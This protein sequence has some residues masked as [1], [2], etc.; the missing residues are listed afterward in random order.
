MPENNNFSQFSNTELT[1]LFLKQSLADSEADFRNSLVNKNFPHWDCIIITASNDSQA[2]GYRRQ[3]DYRRSRKMLPCCAD[4]L[5]VPDKDNKRVGSAG[6]TLSVI[7][8]LKQKY[9]ELRGKKFLVIHAGGNSSRTPQYS[10]LGK[11]FSPVPTAF[12]DTPA[13][14]FDMFMIT[15]SSIPGRIKDGM[16]LLSG[17]VVLLFNPLMCD[18]GASPAA[19]V[20]FKENIDTAKNHGVF[21]KSGDGNVLRFLHKQSKES[22]IKSGAADRR[23]NCNIDTGAL[24]LS[25]EI[26]EK[27]YTLIDT[28][29]KYDS[30]VNEKVRLSLY[31]DIAYCLA[32][33]STLDDFYN[34]SAEGEKCGE[35]MRA[36]RMLW[37]AV[38]SYN[39]K[40]L[41]ISP[42]R[43]IH[44][45]SIPEIMELMNSG[46][47]E[48]KFLNWSN[49]INS[50]IPDPDIAG[51]NS[52][53]SEKATV[54]KGTYL[55]VSYVHSNAKVGK[56]CFLS[57]ID[58][59]DEVIPDGVMMHGIK[60]KNGRF[61]CRIMS[62]C[63][64]PKDRLFFGQDL[65]KILSEDFSV[66]P[67]ALWDDGAEHTLWN[68]A[69]YPECDTIS[70]A[71]RAALDAY[72]LF[73][74]K[75]GSISGWLKQQ[76][77][78]LCS[79]LDGA[80][81]DAIIAWNKRMA[82][83]VHVN[84]LKKRIRASV[85]A[86]ECGG[87]FKEKDLTPIQR[88]W[89]EDEFKKIDL[90]DVDDFAYAIRIYYYLGKLLGN[91]RYVSK[92]F[93]LISKCVLSQS[94]KPTHYNSRLKIAKDEVTVRLPLRVNW[95]GGWTDT[96]PYCIENG[97]TVLNAAIL[98]NGKM[99]VEIKISKIP[100]YKIILDSRDLD[101]HAEFDTV[102]E[103]QKTGDP[104]DPFAIQKAC[105]AACGI[106]TKKGGDLKSILASLGGGFEMRTEVF[107]VPKGSGLGTSSI[108]CAATV[109]AVFEFFGIEYD[110]NRIF[111]TVL[112]VE[113]LM[114]T[115]GGWQDQIGGAVPGIKIITSSKGFGQ[116]VRVRNLSVP[117]K[118]KKELEERFCLIYTGQRRLARN[119][120]RNVVGKY[121]G[122]SPESI[123]A[124]AQIKTLAEKMS[125]SLES[126]DIKTF[127]ALLNEHWE[128]SKI[129]DK[130]STNTLIEQI[131]TGI[132]DLTDA[133][134]ICGAGGGGFLQV[135]LK[136]GVTKADLQNRLKDIFMDFP[137]DVWDCDISY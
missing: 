46:V 82:E 21:L 85:P 66:P 101:E 134:M 136:K 81:P 6:S 131:I 67:A 33:K 39:M 130:G 64:N 53:M 128:C 25:P 127:A 71:V 43:F 37:D 104:F 76:R 97:G 22:L 78:S 24:W 59:H 79:C 117:D 55:E 110:D 103:L 135:I 26:L 4:F 10:A 16:M 7:R 63:D 3:I 57:F 120:L 47:A 60:L 9:G 88:R 126:G 27:L 20:S 45:G 125:D 12:G 51:Y 1:S 77:Q 89:L 123:D 84:E 35:L 29:E 107:G 18:F 58:I 2:E 72:E 95:G 87:I 100:E 93:A 116:D 65:E 86:D 14:L 129:I 5:I 137:I 115:G 121:I 62:I 92:C 54:G 31:G 122:G 91:K 73:I 96:C 15:M 32:E 70:G 68:A 108:L 41:T 99:P 40:L 30:I 19:A 13:T 74:N 98:L 17:D 111:T 61:V 102:S 75:K 124:H 94:L 132:G 83:L 38:G 11:L 119:I 118:M 113:Q 133:K 109:K 52:V 69:I 48:Y 44:F 106:L 105:F 28:D 112:A 114:S 42:A 36:R 56:N 90:G 50:S 49:Q 80:D 8:L 23:G 34:E